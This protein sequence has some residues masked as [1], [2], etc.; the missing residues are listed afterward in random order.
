M[1]FSDD[2]SDKSLYKK[3]KEMRQIL[4]EH[5][6]LKPGLKGFCKNKDS[7]NNQ[8]CIQH[9]LENQLDFFA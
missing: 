1:N 4:H 2:F 8:C 7:I 5:Q 3:P 6:L 9:I